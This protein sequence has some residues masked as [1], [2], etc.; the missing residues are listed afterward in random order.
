MD[1]SSAKNTYHGMISAIKLNEELEMKSQA[2]EEQESHL[3]KHQL[4]T[5]TDLDFLNDKSRDFLIQPNFSPKM[6]NQ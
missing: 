5:K 6:S 3:D 4:L 1:Q 2:R